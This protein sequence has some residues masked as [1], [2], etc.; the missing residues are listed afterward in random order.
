MYSDSSKI[1]V[2]SGA[3]VIRFHFFVSDSH[4][5]AACAPLVAHL[6][7][8]SGAQQ[9]CIIYWNTMRTYQQ[10]QSINLL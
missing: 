3:D 2:N 10:S 9:V 4:H 7:M 5:I 1:G 8:R 6:V